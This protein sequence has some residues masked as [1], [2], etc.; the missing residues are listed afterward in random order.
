MAFIDDSSVAFGLLS[1][2]REE[3]LDSCLVELDELVEDRLGD[4]RIVGRDADLAGVLRFSPGDAADGDFEV[5]RRDLV[6]DDDGAFGAELERA[7]RNVLGGGFGYD[8][9]DA[10]VAGVEDCRIRK[11]AEKRCQLVERGVRWE[12]KRKRREVQKSRLTH[13]PA[14]V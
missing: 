6:V 11:E 2:I 8:A 13:V 12:R 9:S 4:N 7:G 1:A 14:Q 5:V 10:L 3:R